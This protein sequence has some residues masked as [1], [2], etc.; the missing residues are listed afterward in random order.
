MD[1]SQ[2]ADVSNLNPIA[3]CVL[4][5]AAA[6]MW[7]AERST[8]AIILLVAALLMPL[9]QQLVVLGLHFRIY[10]LLVLAGMAR[11]LL[12]RDARGFKRQPVDSI[13]VGWVLV[14]LG[15]GVAR[16]AR[17]ETFGIA[18]DALGTF[19]LFRLWIRR[20]ADITQHLRVLAVAAAALALCLGLEL[21]TRRNFFSI[22]GGVP[23]MTLV[24]DGHIR[25]QGPFR[26]PILAGSFAATLFPLMLALR[27]APDSWR[28]RRRSLAGLIASV[29]AIASAA[30]SGPLLTFFSALGGIFLWPWRKRIKFLRYATI[31]IVAALATVM[32][33]PVWF[34]IARVSDV[35]G[36]TGWHRAYLIDQAVTRFDEWWLI[37]SSRTAHWAIDPGTILSMDPENMDITNQYI[38]QGLQG[39]L[40]GLA[41][42]VAII[43]QCFSIVGR[44]AG[45]QTLALQ[46][47]QFGWF[48]GVS[49]F[50]H[51]VTFVSVSYFDQIL[52]YFYWLVA[53]IAGQSAHSRALPAVEPRS[54]GMRDG[55]E[56]EPA[57]SLEGYN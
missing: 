43:L 52:V 56:K 14:T 9:G 57:Y 13:F 26:H 29:L 4:L 33:A 47:R 44:W 37:G 51:C 46:D 48:L 18:F 19:F 17:A 40:L 53:T 49:L 25:A 5:V 36:G 12:R 8:A 54:P 10:R 32:N 23:E 31:G 50:A 24:R 34:L 55:L 35:F 1:A 38:A 20:T 27:Y 39:G 41:L 2:A 28:H 11:A 3:L 6:W 30:S 22:F 7:R 15:C 45:N 16:G 42:F 21:L